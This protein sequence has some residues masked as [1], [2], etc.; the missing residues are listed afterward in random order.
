MKDPISLKIPEIGLAIL[1]WG[2]IA[3][4]IGGS[5]FYLTAL[6]IHKWGLIS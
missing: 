5:F 3:I 2:L 4:A 6:I 1:L